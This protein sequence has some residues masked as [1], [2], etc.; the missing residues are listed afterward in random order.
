PSPCT[1]GGLTP[2]PASDTQVTPMDTSPPSPSPLFGSPPGSSR[3]LFPSSQALQT[4]PRDSAASATVST[5][6]PGLRFSCSSHTRAPAQPTSGVPDVQQ[7]RAPAWGH[8]PHCGNPAAPAL[9]GNP[10]SAPGP[11]APP[12]NSP[13]GTRASTQ[14]ASAAFPAGPAPAA[15]TCVPQAVP[16]AG[17]RSWPRCPA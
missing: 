7:R 11:P 5:S 1:S 6:L 8:S 2:H 16:S 9:T 12:T 15:A 10:T 3:S 14:P 17:P 4:P 13:M